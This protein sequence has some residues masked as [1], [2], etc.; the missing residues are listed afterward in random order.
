MKDFVKGLK[1]PLQG[2]RLIARPGIRMFVVIPFLINTVLFSAVIYY[3]AQQIIDLNDWLSSRW[4]WAEWLA[5]LIWPIFLLITVTVV[6]YGFTLVANIISA[7]FNGFLAEAVEFHLT[8]SRPE[9][10]ANLTGLPH[11]IITSVKN[12]LGKF[13]YFAVRA[14]PL[15]I[16]FIIPFVNTVAPFIW[17]LFSSWLIALEYMDFPLSN[18]GMQFSEIREILKPRRDLCI[19]FGMG[20]LLMTMIPVLNFLAM[21]VAVISATK[22][23]LKELGKYK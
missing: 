13:L 1:Y 9:N 12:E 15:L 3:G 11:E 22:L 10:S 6:F 21:P 16:L 8:G 19:G 17:V 14:L 5:W 18:H 2:F 7:P 20:T 23:M 4:D